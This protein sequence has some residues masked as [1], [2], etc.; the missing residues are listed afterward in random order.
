MTISLP[1]GRLLPALLVAAAAAAFALPAAAKSQVPG[2]A[3]GEV[4][5]RHVPTRGLDLAQPGDRKR[6]RHRIGAAV[7]ELCGDGWYEGL[8]RRMLAEACRRNAAFGAEP[9]VAA[10]VRR[11]VQFAEARAA[12]RPA[13]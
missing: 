10:L 6:L 9:Q 5:V 4:E 3:A 1:R 11:D 7:E 8:E 2:V 12:L 13:G